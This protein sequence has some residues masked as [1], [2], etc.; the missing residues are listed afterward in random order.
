MA[1]IVIRY[2]G[3][4]ISN[5]VMFRETTFSS[6][7]DGIPG[8][9][10]VVINNQNQQWDTGDFVSGKTLELLVDGVRM[11]DGWV[12]NVNRS[13]PFPALD[14]RTP[15]SIPTRWTLQGLDRN[16][17]LQKRVLYRQ[18]DPDDPRGFKI[19]PQGT[20][21]KKALNYV[22]N[23]YVDLSGDNLKFD[24]R[25]IDT[26]GPYEDFTLGYVGAPLGVAFEDCAKM[27]GGVFFIS[28]KRVLT[29]LSDLIPTKSWGLSDVPTGNDVG[30]REVKA[31]L[32]FS[33]AANEAKVWGAGKGD[34]NPVFANVR[35]SDSVAKYGLWQWGDL[36][37]GAYKQQT[38]NRRA[39]TYIYGSPSHRRGHDEP[40]P[41][42][43]CAVFNTSLHAGDVVNFTMES[44]DYSEV[45]PIRQCSITFPTPNDIRQ[46]L[47]LS[48]NVD[49]PF[50]APDLWKTDWDYR[51][52]KTKTGGGEDVSPPQDPLG[53]LIDDFTSATFGDGYVD[54][55]YVT[56]QDVVPSQ[57]GQWTVTI[58]EGQAGDYVVIGLAT[59]M[60]YVDPDEPPTGWTYGGSEF[61]FTE[62]IGSG[63]A[64]YTRQLDGTEN[65][66]VTFDWQFVGDAEYIVQLGAII[67]G[68]R[69]ASSMEVQSTGSTSV[70]WTWGTD[71]AILLINGFG[72]V[73]AS[74][75]IIRATLPDYPSETVV[76]SRDYDAASPYYTGS[77]TTFAV[78]FQIPDYEAQTDEILVTPGQDVTDA[79]WPGGNYYMDTNLWNAENKIG[80]S[81]ATGPVVSSFD[82]A[83]SMWK[84]N[85]SKT[86]A[87][88]ESSASAYLFGSTYAVTS[89]A[90]PPVGTVITEVP[91]GP[92]EGISATNQSG[93]LNLL[94]KWRMDPVPIWDDSGMAIPYLAIEYNPVVWKD[95]VA[96]LG[97]TF[98]TPFGPS[99]VSGGSSEIRRAMPYMEDNRNYYPQW[100]SGADP[101]YVG[102]TTAVE[103]PTEFDAAQY[104]TGIY[105]DYYAYH[106]NEWLYT[107]IIW[108][109]D[110]PWTATP[111]WTN[112]SGSTTLPPPSV[113]GTAKMR[114]WL[115]SEAEPV[116][117][118]YPLF[119]A[120]PN[121]GSGYEKWTTSPDGW[122]CA[123]PFQ[124]YPAEDSRYTYTYT[125]TAKPFLRI[126]KALTTSYGGYQTNNT[127]DIDWIRAYVPGIPEYQPVS[128]VVDDDEIQFISV[129][130]GNALYQTK[131]PYASGTLRVYVQGNA[132]RYRLDYVEVDPSEGTF[133][134]FEEKDWSQF[135]RASYTMLSF[136]TILFPLRYRPVPLRHN[137]YGTQYDGLNLLFACSAMA[138]S[139]HTRNGVR[140]EPPEHRQWS[141]VGAGEPTLEDLDEAWQA[142]WGR[143]Y[144]AKGTTTF[145]RFKQFI[146]DGR[147]AVLMGDY[148][149]LP[150]DKKNGVWTKRHALYVNDSPE[151]GKYW[152]CDPLEGYGTIYTEQELQ[153]YAAGVAGSGNVYANFTDPVT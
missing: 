116:G 55:Q 149:A 53:S 73:G 141:T 87:F 145:G 35:N 13:W 54:S 9:C 49:H 92:W 90:G 134:L 58:D 18:D 31:T 120:T 20:P 14:T 38:V 5:D 64:F 47:V 72:P 25:E 103:E 66:E 115:A 123:V 126:Y 48:L 84:T 113:A 88:G 2:D 105:G 75:E 130:D 17:L 79:P 27:T 109:P 71:A 125:D 40:V 122:H 30:Y 44:F 137:G 21:D 133:R 86:A 61:N 26:P 98:V 1:V 24:I 135:M 37:L 70:T 107:R 91:W 97:D 153:D 136:E 57:T 83:N 16:Y 62:G 19:W 112:Q 106:Q 85:L 7:A 43:E 46:D 144:P 104:V 131:Y 140:T 39:R 147:G 45:L 146:Q 80:I 89:E 150:E 102:W 151:S 117:G 101:V 114:T 12:F 15:A 59:S 8:Q 36:F 81:D 100:G 63:W 94:I 68:V 22:L 127:I 111:Y 139:H 119:L 121:G 129:T 56:Y 3:V 10:S 52:T 32:D 95:G 78:I 142:G 128:G 65:N 132:L 93:Y 42:V 152:A 138:L 28:P 60:A 148:D 108:D 6:Q 118:S 74:D 41:M 29:Y 23:N 124:C 33:L 67:Y 11:W 76:F 34:A 82:Y 96:Y 143:S 50:T 51:K 99:Y 77:T 69:N 110:D 4:N